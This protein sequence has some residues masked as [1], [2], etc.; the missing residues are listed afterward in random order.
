MPKSADQLD[1]TT[2][3][4]LNTIFLY[5]ETPLGTKIFDYPSF[6]FC[7]TQCLMYT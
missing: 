7:Q 6:K 5:N 4:K 1:P 3:C 2:P